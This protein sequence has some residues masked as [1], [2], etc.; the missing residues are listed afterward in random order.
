M[1]SPELHRHALWVLLPTL[2]T[3]DPNLQYYYDFEPALAEY[4]QVFSALGC[5]WQWRRVRLDSIAAVLDEIQAESAGRLPLIIN[6]C[7][8][9]EVNGAPGISVIHEMEARKLAYTGARAPYY[10][11]TTSK[12]LLKRALDA[13]GVNTAPWQEIVDDVPPAAVFERCGLPLI[14]KPAVSGGSMGLSVRNVVTDLQQLQSILD[15]LRAGYRGWNLTWG[16]ILAERFVRGRE[17]TVLLVGSGD[18]TR[19]YAPAELVFHSSLAEDERFLSFDRLWETF[20]TEAAMPNEE[21]FYQY[22]QPEPS[23][24]PALQ[25]LSLA[26]YRAVGGSGYGRVDIRQDAASGELYVLEV[27]A[28]C[29]LSEDENYTAIG[30]I[31][32]FESETFAQLTHSILSDAMA[33]S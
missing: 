28:Q 11:A 29:G 25:A 27:N 5:P 4:T 21:F 33:S 6:L 23:L 3:K 19:C 9:D 31:L 14:V 26:A 30:A 12:I 7:D 16:G 24:V 15:E 18:R 10:L 1:F 2:E 13:A 20:E 8:G 32:K 22:A 17:F